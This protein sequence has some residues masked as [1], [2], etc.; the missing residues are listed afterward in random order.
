MVFPKKDIQVATSLERAEAENA[1]F[2]RKS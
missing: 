1:E 2:F